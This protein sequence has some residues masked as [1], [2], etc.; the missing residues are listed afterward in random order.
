M[1]WW[2]QE[3]DG[4]LLDP[5]WRWLLLKVAAGSLSARGI[6]VDRRAGGCGGQSAADRRGPTWPPRVPVIDGSTRVRVRRRSVEGNCSPSFAS[7]RSHSRPLESSS[8]RSSFW[9]SSGRPRPRMNNTASWSWSASDSST[10]SGRRRAGRPSRAGASWAPEAPRAS[11]DPPARDGFVARA[12]A[13]GFPTS[14]SSALVPNSG[15]R[16]SPPRRRSGMG[17]YLHR[18][19]HQQFSDCGAVFAVTCSARVVPID[20]LLRGERLTVAGALVDDGAQQLVR[21]VLS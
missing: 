12:G 20:R 9:V 5:E 1:A 14:R 3:L 6:Q 10:F 21:E 17:R 4:R 16:A 2:H 19:R 8:S 7:S 18:S 11:A 15:S 13:T